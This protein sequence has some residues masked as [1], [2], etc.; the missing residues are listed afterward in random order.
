MKKFITFF[1]ALIF[2]LNL[3]AQQE[4][5]TTFK[6]QM[7]TMFSTLDKTRVPHGILLNFGMEFTNVPAFNGALTDSTYSKYTSL[8]QIYNTLLSSRIRDVSTGFVSPNDYDS[9]WQNNRTKGVITIGGLYF[10][11]SQFLPDAVAMNKL[12]YSNGKFYDKFIRGVWQNPYQ[13]MQTFAM[14]PIAR[15]YEGKNITIKIPTNTF[16]SNY[17]NMVQKIEIDFDNGNGYITVPFN[18]NVSVVYQNIGTKI[19]KYRLTLTNGAALLNHSLFKIEEGIETVP[20]VQNNLLR[21]TPTGITQNPLQSIH[22]TANQS[23]LGTYGS[24]KLTIDVNSDGII[25]KPLIVAEGFDM[26]VLLNPENING[27]QNY[28]DFKNSIYYSNSTLL[29][30]LIYE[31]NK[32]Y[33]II[34]IDWDNGVDYLQRNAYVLETVIEWVNQQKALSG[35]TEPNVVL[36]QSM[37]GVISRYALADM[38]ERNMNHDTH[39]FVSDDAPQQGAN[40]PIGIQFMYRH[41]TNQYVSTPIALLGGEVLIPIFTGNEPVSSYLSILDTPAARQLLSNWSSIYYSIINTSHDTF[42][43]ELKNKGINPQSNGGYPINCRKVAISNGSECGNTQNFY[44]GQELMSYQWNKDLNFWGD[45][46]S[47]LYVPLGGFIAGTL[48]DENF[49]GVVILGLIPGSSE[50][51]ID[52]K[53]NSISYNSNN[54]IYKGVISYK[55]KILWFIPVTVYITNVQKNQ[56]SGILPY[57]TYGGGYYPTGNVLSNSSNEHLFIRDRFNFIPTTSALDIGN[58]NTQL[59][60][61]DYKNTYI[62]QFP[63]SVPKNTLFDNFCTEFDKYNPNQTN[64]PHIS[65]NQRNG[66]WLAGELNS[67]VSYT[68]CSYACSDEQIDGENV[69]CSNNT[70]SVPSG[71]GFYNWS[72]I[73]GE[74]LVAISNGNGTNVI[75][76]NDLNNGNGYVTVRVYF[77]DNW[78]KCGNRVLTKRIWVGKPIIN[79]PEDCW[80]ANPTTPNCFTICRQFE[81]TMNNFVYVEAQGTD[82]VS[83]QTE[84]WEWQKITNNFT[85]IPNFNSAY[86]NPLL[87]ATPQNYLGYKVRVKNVCGWSDWFEN[88]LDIKDCTNGLETNKLTQDYFVIYPNPVKDLINVELRDKQ[89]IPITVNKI[90]G[91]IFDIIGISKGI[92]EFD[93]NQSKLIVRD[94]KEGVYVL[95]VYLDN[96]VENHQII[97]NQR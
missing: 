83:L 40:I 13:E 50:Y 28:Y 59:D 81:Q 67:A 92:L 86:I 85:L 91:E 45:L 94:L 80:S 60:D 16:Y 32:Q 78:I 70:Y 56:P 25:N 97:I 19:W 23:Y 87:N 15:G 22:I 18:Q 7:N 38:E 62:G 64:K 42:Y 69:I 90:S 61:S 14:S 52:F 95:K 8:K 66:D 75:T 43:S 24:C 37:G 55:K 71:A 58:D 1:L 44:P 88:Y 65:F 51:N 12:T 20:Y 26:G 53:A 47:M 29:R 79:L 27:Y 63:P 73:E 49:Y 68:N 6:N 96:N 21:T 82:Q 10:K 31:N 74:N 76:L 84:N 4:I 57:D 36:G 5:N 35:S 17:Q 41:I 9:R 11:Y 48:L 89:N 39:L 93:N 46:L 3:L 2:S 34:Y 72:I 33:D 30:N 77:G 54:Q